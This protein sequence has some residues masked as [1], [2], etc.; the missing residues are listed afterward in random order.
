M[1]P[2]IYGQITHFEHFEKLRYEHHQIIPLVN[3]PQI[4]LTYFVQHVDIR[5]VSVIFG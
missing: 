2:D 5:F 4:S 3:L 1:V